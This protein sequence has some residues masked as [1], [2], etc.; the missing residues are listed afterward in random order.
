VRLYSTHAG[1]S[2]RESYVP[3]DL[4]LQ[5]PRP[6][7]VFSQ[8]GH[9]SRVTEAPI[10]LTVEQAANRLNQSPRQIARYIDRGQL[11]ALHLGRSVRVP[12]GELDAFVARVMQMQHPDM[13][14]R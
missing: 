1:W 5:V 8:G 3:V 4:S 10:L 7:R 13:E 6:V 11:R 14:D 12:I 9:D 2:E